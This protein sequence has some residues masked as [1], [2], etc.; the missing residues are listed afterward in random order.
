M[1]KVIKAI[2]QD[3]SYRSRLVEITIVTRRKLNNILVAYTSTAQY[4]SSR[5]REDIPG[6]NQAEKRAYIDNI[7]KESKRKIAKLESINELAA[8]VIED[9]DKAAWASKGILQGLE[10]ATQKEFSI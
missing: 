5:Y 4:I 7:L 1:E 2:A 8:Y 10:I 6:S 9:I 3:Q